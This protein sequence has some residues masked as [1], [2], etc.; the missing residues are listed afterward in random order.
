MYNIPEIPT[1]HKNKWE[2][3]FS[4]KCLF[5]FLQWN[6]LTQYWSNISSSNSAYSF[7]IPKHI[8]MTKCQNHPFQSV[9][10]KTKLV[11]IAFYLNSQNYNH[12]LNF[13]EFQT[14]NYRHNAKQF[15]IPHVIKSDFKWLTFWCW[16]LSIHN[17]L[18]ILFRFWQL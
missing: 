9:G 17:R 18:I 8:M 13:Y 7:T 5:K 4:V 16:K 1:E 12:V 15:I 10:H 6:F 11:S 14:D 2:S 3:T